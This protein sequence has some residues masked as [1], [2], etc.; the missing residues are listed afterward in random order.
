MRL[1]AP[2]NAAILVLIAALYGAGAWEVIPKAGFQV[3]LVALVAVATVVWVRVERW[4]LGALHPAARVLRIIGALA[5][6]LVA[7]PILVLMPLLYL[8]AGISP[9]AGIEAVIPRVMGLLLAGEVLTV[10]VNVL[11]LILT[12]ALSIAGAHRSGAPAR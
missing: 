8:A 1:L 12:A 6:A 5:L 3:L 2:T 10:A 4:R 11:G 9:S 7:T